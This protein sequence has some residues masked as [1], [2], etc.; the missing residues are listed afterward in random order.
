MQIEHIC[1]FNFPKQSQTL[2][3]HLRASQNLTTLDYEGFEYKMWRGYS[4]TSLELSLALIHSNQ[5]MCGTKYVM[6]EIDTLVPPKITKSK[7]KWGKLAPP[8]PNCV[9]LA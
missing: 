6:H 2:D 4:N 8:N 1:A 3:Q 5:H 7:Q 9:D